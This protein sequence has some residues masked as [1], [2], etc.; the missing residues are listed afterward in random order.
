M[1]ILIDLYLSF[2]NLEENELLITVL[3]V[4][5]QLSNLFITEVQSD[6]ILRTVSDAIGP[7]M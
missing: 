1:Q 6:I 5:Y 3:K 7:A 2:L 4:F